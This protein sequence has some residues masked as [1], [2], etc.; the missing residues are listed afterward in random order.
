MSRK[1]FLLVIASFGAA[2]LLFFVAIG[3]FAFLH[4]GSQETGANHP[5]VV[6]NPTPPG[7]PPPPEIS[8][9]IRKLKT[10]NSLIVQW[11]NLPEDTAA[12][13]LFCSALL[14][15]TTSSTWTLWKEILLSSGELAAGNR[16]VA[17]GV[18]YQ[19]CSF[20]VVQAIG[21]DRVGKLGIGATTTLEFSG[22]LNGLNQ[23]GESALWTSGITQPSVTTS[24][25]GL[26]PGPPPP[27]PPSRPATSTNP[28]NPSTS[29]P[30]PNPPA[31]S[32]PTG[33]PVYNPPPTPSGTP[34]Y[35]PQVQVIA[36]AA[37]GSPIFWV[38]HANQGIEIGWQNLPPKTDTIVILR[39]Q[40]D[41]GPWEPFMT[42]K[43]LPTN[44]Y[45]LQIIDGNANVPYYYEMQASAGTSTIAIFGP[46]FL[47]PTAP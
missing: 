7:P 4:S 1:F 9:T 2:L 24:T 41:D 15:P 10:G 34:Y 14:K 28:S 31:S 35:N 13:D 22:N 36:Y 20:Y 44:N 6:A 33:T 30:S 47:A 12:L 17:L 23:N 40:T 43:N 11:T 39:S 42:Q 5:P 25:A 19:R 38:Q 3:G 27:P 26:P 29:T 32:T 8:L 21:K 37:S 46:D 16:E 45:S 18:W